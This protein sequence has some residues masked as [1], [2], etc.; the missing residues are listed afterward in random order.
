MDVFAS[1]DQATMNKAE[2]A[3]F[4]Q[5]GTR[6]DFVSNSLVLIVP[7][8]AKVLPSTPQGLRNDAVKRIAIGNPDSVPVGRYTRETLTKAGE[9]EALAPKFIYGQSVRQVLDYVARGEADAGFVYATDAK[10][11]EDKV[12]VMAVMQGHEPIL[13]PI[14]AVKGSAN[15]ALAKA[16]VEFVRSPQ[17]QAVLKGYGFTTP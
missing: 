9:W 3:G 16:F 11:A 8:D 6:A 5:P 14:A 15:P 12:R 2:Q 1:A 10:I 13:Y 4:I 17:G 7:K